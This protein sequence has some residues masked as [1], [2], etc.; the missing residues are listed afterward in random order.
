MDRSV[1][2][3]L[4]FVGVGC[5]KFTL[6]QSYYSNQL[7]HYTGESHYS[8]TELLLLATPNSRRLPPNPSYCLA[9]STATHKY[10]DKLF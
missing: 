10:C 5:M 1:T 6:D 9:I 3:I 8:I 4:Y 2:I 7:E